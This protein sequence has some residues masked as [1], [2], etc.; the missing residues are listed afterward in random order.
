MQIRPDDR[1]LAVCQLFQETLDK[2][3]K[4]LCCPPT[5]PGEVAWLAAQG[6][7]D[8][9]LYDLPWYMPRFIMRTEDH[10]RMNGCLSC[11]Q[12]YNLPMNCLLV[13]LSFLLDKKHMPFLFKPGEWTSIPKMIHNH[14][15]EHYKRRPTQYHTHKHA[16]IL[17]IR[18]VWRQVF[19]FYIF[20]KHEDIL[21]LKYRVM[22]SDMGNEAFAFVVT[23]FQTRIFSL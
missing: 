15:N 1:A 8:V 5:I 18:R 17:R 20:S 6:I 22:V 23:R 3:S 12:S 14:R 19:A 21:P 10:I 13:I 7:N 9:S 4:A 2:D 16:E 11:L